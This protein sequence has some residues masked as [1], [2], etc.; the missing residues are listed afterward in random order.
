[1]FIVLRFYEE[2]EKE[3]KLIPSSYFTELF[4]KFFYSIKI[5]KNCRQ[6]PTKHTPFDPQNHQYNYT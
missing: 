2:R 4:K 5:I 3:P 6:K 1:M